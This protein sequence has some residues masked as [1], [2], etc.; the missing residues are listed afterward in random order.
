MFLLSLNKIPLPPPLSGQVRKIRTYFA[1]FSL[2]F[3]PSPLWPFATI[4]H[5]RGS[6]RT[7]TP[8]TDRPRFSS[9]RSEGVKKAVSNPSSLFLLHTAQQHPTGRLTHGGGFQVPQ[10]GKRGK[11]KENVLFLAD[12]QIRNMSLLAYFIS[13]LWQQRTNRTCGALAGFAARSNR[14]TDSKNA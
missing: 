5:L 4:K 14:Q 2:S 12:L 13:S 8:P 6:F 11:E 3:L 9:A 10:R 1:N 7:D